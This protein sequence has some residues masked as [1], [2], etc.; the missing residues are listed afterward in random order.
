MMKAALIT[1]RWVYWL[2]AGEKIRDKQPHTH[3]HT[4]VHMHLPI[5]GRATEGV[6]MYTC[7]YCVVRIE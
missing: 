6:Y 1:V 5:G 3:T 7:G 4:H 2:K